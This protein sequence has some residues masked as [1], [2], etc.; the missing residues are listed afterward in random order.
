MS[1]LSKALAGKKVL[2]RAR[3]HLSRQTSAHHVQN[4]VYVQ[5]RAADAKQCFLKLRQRISSVQAILV[6]NDVVSKAMV[7]FASE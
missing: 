4:D 7:K 6:V 3:V 2:L 1:E 5:L